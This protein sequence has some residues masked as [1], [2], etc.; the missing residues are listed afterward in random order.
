MAGKE[1]YP[2]KPEDEFARAIFDGNVSEVSRL[3]ENGRSANEK[4]DDACPV[5]FVAIEGCSFSIVELLL[6][7]G[8]DVN[9]VD[10]Y[11]STPLHLAV[12]N[13]VDANGD[14]YVLLDEEEIDIVV[15]LLKAGADVN[16]LTERGESPIDIAEEYGFEKV[17]SLL[18]SYA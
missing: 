7:N 15:C 1:L 10:K 16:L 17:I 14:D 12:E 11:G 18:R 2:G 8:A 3:L 9:T 6:N 13:T 5:L 4:I